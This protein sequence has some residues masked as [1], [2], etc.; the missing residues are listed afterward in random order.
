MIHRTCSSSHRSFP[1][2]A[3]PLYSSRRSVLAGR[4]DS[5]GTAS[6]NSSKEGCCA[7]R[8]VADECKCLHGRDIRSACGYDR[9]SGSSRRCGPRVRAV[10][11]RHRDIR[12][13]LLIDMAVRAES[14]C[15]AVPAGRVLSC[16]S[17]SQDEMVVEM[18]STIPKSSHRRRL[19]VDRSSRDCAEPVKFRSAANRLRF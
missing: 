4:P 9:N 17:A 7:S 14:D 10:A 11:A 12:L 18:A 15:V 13:I 5:S 8:R 3:I 2:V 1:A 16:S 6:F 19:E